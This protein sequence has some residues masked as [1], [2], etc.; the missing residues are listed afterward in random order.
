[1]LIWMGSFRVARLFGIDILVHWS[2]LAIFFLLVWSLA[3]GFFEDVGGD[4]WS[5]ASRWIAAVITSLSFFASILLHELSHSLVA[6][7]LGLPVASITLFI[8]GGVSALGREPDSARDEFKVAIAGPATS[9]VIAALLGLAFLGFYLADAEDSV[10]GAICG[11]LGFINLAVGIFNMLPGYP[12]DG[13]R[14]LRSALW[15]GT[16]NMLKATRWAATSGTVISFVLIT[17]GVLSV[18]AGG[19]V[20]GIW[21]IVI[22]WFLRNSSD[23]AYQQVLITNTLSGVKVREMVSQRYAPAAPDDSLSHIVSEHF[24]GQGYRCV[25]VVVAG[26]LLGIITMTDLRKIPQ[27]QWPATSAFRA[28]TPRE[29]LEVVDPDDELLHALQIM[30]ANEI[31][32]VPVID[33]QR[34]FLGLVTRE[35]VLRL[36]HLKTELGQAAAPPPRPRPAP[37]P[38]EARW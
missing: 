29:R 20:G 6:K 23:Q 24:L 17:A 11:Y 37:G 4:D 12:L 34:T 16:R 33:R 15:A 14:V 25:P 1:M 9:F 27:E 5:D 10:P 35:D 26:D 3:E 38:T 21:F 19:F 13:G 7:R 18:L 30:A 32:Q 31:N 36:I 2:W 28:M 8:F 22:G